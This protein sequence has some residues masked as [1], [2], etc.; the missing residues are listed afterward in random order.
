MQSSPNN[1]ARRKCPGC[2][3][4][5]PFRS[6][7]KGLDHLFFFFGRK[8][9]RCGTCRKRFYLDAADV[10]GPK[11]GVRTENRDRRRAA[12]RREHIVY[13]AALLAF[14]AAAFLII[15]ERG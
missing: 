2:G 4:E 8:P 9:F 12:R 15:Q 14:L 11:T 7:R 13:L 1:T 6:H 3:A 10:V 5:R